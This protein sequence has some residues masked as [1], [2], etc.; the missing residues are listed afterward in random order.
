MP[1]PSFELCGSAEAGEVAG[2]R[3]QPRFR[4]KTRVRCFAALAA[5]RGP[6]PVR[7][8]DLPAVNGKK[9]CRMQGA[10]QGSGAPA[11]NQN[12]LSMVPIRANC[13]NGAHVSSTSSKTAQTAPAFWGSDFGSPKFEPAK[14]R[15]PA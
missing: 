13:S 9:R 3:G 6:V 4:K 5:E 11:G 10:C 1:V 7:R 15:T 14:F 2:L 8:A 12:A